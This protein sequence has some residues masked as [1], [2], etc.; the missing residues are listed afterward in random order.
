[1]LKNFCRQNKI[2]VALGIFIVIFSLVQYIQPM[3]LYNK[4][5]SIRQFGIG[6]K[7]KT[8]FPI[9]L[10]SIVLAIFSYL[11]VLTIINFC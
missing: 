8:I 7:N 6:Y 5:G 4:D 10:F 11:F 3:F 1:M 2:L 9:W